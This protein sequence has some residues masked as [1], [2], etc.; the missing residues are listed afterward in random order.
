MTIKNAVGLVRESTEQQAGE[1][2]AGIPA[3]R[4]ANRR[5]AKVYGLKLVKSIEI[6]DVSGTAVLR[7]PKM[8]ELLELMES[9]EIHGVVAKEFSRLMRPENFADYALLQHFIDTGTVLYLPE[10]PIDFASKSGRLY[11]TVRAAMAGLERREIIE[12]MQD[13]KE[14]MRRAGKHPCGS[15]TLPYG[16]GYSKEAGWFYTAE[17]EKVRGAFKLFLSGVGYTEISRQLNIPRSNLRFILQNPVYIGWRVYKE[18]RDP[19][20]RAY[21]PR[22]DGRQGDRPK[23]PRAPEEVIRVK[24]LDG[25]V[26]EADF[27]RV[28]EMIELKSQK[29]SRAR[30]ETSSRYTYNGFLVC[31]DCR[32]LIYTHSS[33][34]DFY[35]CKTHNPRERRKRESQGHVPCANRHMLRKKLEP[36]IDYLLGEKLREEQFLHSVLEGYERQLEEPPKD[37]VDREALES[38]LESLRAKKERVLNAF[39]DGVIDKKERDKKLDA[40]NKEIVAYQGLLLQPPATVVGPPKLDLDAVLTIIEPFAEWEFLGRE[41]RRELLTL[42]CPA[43]NVYRYEI[44]DLALNL[45]LETSGG[46]EDSRKRTVR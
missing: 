46:H 36:K 26:S 28:Q 24:V 2:R 32:S 33:K 34:Y 9:P 27:A 7:S 39:Y 15:A 38:R 19:S 4:E 3:Q 40:L 8:K 18:K 37:R 41:D 20:S 42:L 11:G 23:I 45:P 31:G 1:D 10:G 29:H 43:I 25:L 16:V 12:R 35:V 30:S 44:K 17:S 13:A 6:I 22:P 21:C 5:T 14:A